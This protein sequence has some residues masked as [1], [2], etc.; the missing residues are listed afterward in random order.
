MNHESVS[1]KICQKGG[2]PKAV[3]AN[4]ETTAYYEYSYDYVQIDLTALDS[5]GNALYK[6]GNSYCVFYSIVINNMSYEYTVLFE[7]T[8]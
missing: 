4:V 8:D 1:Y 5:G 6:A 3:S 7:I 2:S